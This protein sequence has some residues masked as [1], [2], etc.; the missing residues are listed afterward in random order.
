MKR[1]S[2]QPA[3]Q[4][5]LLS[6]LE[7]AILLAF[8]MVMLL[9]F[10][11]IIVYILPF[12]IG[13]VIAVI[14]FPLVHIF[15]RWGM[16]RRMSIVSTLVL[17]IAVLLG[18]IGFLAVQG[19]EEAISLSQS[20]PHYFHSWAYSVSQWIEQ[21]MAVYGHLPPKIVSAVQSAT[22]TA[23]DQVRQVALAVLSGV[24]SGV[25][26]L[27][28]VIVVIV[29]SVVAAYFFMAQR[30]SLINGLKKILPP[31]WAPKLGLVA[32]DVGRALAGLARA[33]VIL[34]VVTSVICVIGLLVMGV[35]YALIL[36]M[37]IGLTGWVP[38]LGSG[39]VT[40]PWALGAVALGNY[41]LA[42]KILLLQAVASLVRH[43]IEPKILASNMELGTFATL[44][45]MYVGLTSIGFIGLLLGPI[46]LIAV[47]SLIR[48]RM[49]I[50]FFPNAEKSVVSS[51]NANSGQKLDSDH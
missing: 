36:G 44:F 4:R 50:D 39:I 45:G 1:V 30:E 15:E 11:K 28:D 48:A 7:V 32:G 31:G 6:V 34:I 20:L 5:Y 27:P 49:F 26:F 21:G 43:T 2:L 3:L 46:L 51:E 41:V 33:Q 47:R 18:L 23:V 17:V 38:I 10:A 24:F 9:L 37:L 40:L 16:S 22:L 19:A 35:H 14:L 13:F 25:A 12:I 29:I 42:I 8:V